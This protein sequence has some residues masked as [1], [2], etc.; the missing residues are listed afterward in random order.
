M[1]TRAAPNYKNSHP[2]V[3]TPRMSLHPDRTLGKCTRKWRVE[4][5]LFQVDL[6]KRIG[7]NEMTIVNWER[8]GTK[9]TKKN[10]ERL[11]IIWGDLLSS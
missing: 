8:G 2:L 7:V 9:P 1:N 6:A 3:V 10:L 11:E 5:G 4:Q